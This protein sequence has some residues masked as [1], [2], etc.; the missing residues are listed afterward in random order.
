MKDKF[1]FLIVFIIL[2]NASIVSSAII[3]EEKDIINILT[4]NLTAFLQLIDTPGSY[5]GAGTQCVK[6]NAGATALEF[7]ACGSG[8]LD[9]NA[10]SICANGQVLMGDGYCLDLNDTID[11]RGT[12]DNGSWNQSFA[13]T[14]FNETSLVQSINTTNVLQLILNGTNM[15]LDILNVSTIC[16]DDDCID[17]WQAVN[18]SALGTVP[19]VCDDDEVQLGNGSCRVSDPWVRNNTFG[20]TLN[21]TKVFSLDWSNITILENQITDLTHTTDTNASTIC[22]GE[23]VLLGNSSC[24][25][26]TIF[27]AGSGDVIN[28]TAGWILNFTNI[29]SDDWSNV[30]I[31]E[32]Q[33]T[34][35]THIVDT[36]ETSRMLNLTLS[37]CAVGQQV[38]GVQTNGTV[39]CVEDSS[40]NVTY[41]LYNDTDLVNALNTTSA[42][43]TL[44]ND[45]N[46]N[47]NNI[48]SNA[49]DNVTIVEAQITDLVHTENCNSS[50]ACSSGDVAYMDI[51]NTGDFNVSANITGDIQ[52]STFGKGEETL[53]EYFDDVS[54]K[55]ILD[56]FSVTNPD[57]ALEVN[58]T[59]GEIYDVASKAIIQVNDGNASCT[60]EAVNHLVWSS[61]NTLSLQV[62]DAEGDEISVAHISCENGHVFNIH[63]E[64]SISKRESSI[65][66]GLEAVFPVIVASGLIVSEDTDVTNPLDVVLSA[67]VYYHDVQER[68]EIP[69]ILSRAKV[70]IRW[71]HNSSGDFV[72]DTNAEIDATQYDSGTGLIGTTAARFYS[73]CWFLVNDTLHWIYPTT[74]HVLVAQ[75]ISNGCPTK[76]TGF[77]NEPFL[78]RV[79]MKGDDATFPTAG[80]DRW[81]DI[82]PIIESQTGSAI[83]TDHGELIGLGDDDH[84]QYMVLTGARSLTGDWNQGNFNFT[85]LTSWFFGF[86]NWTSLQNV[87]AFVRN[88]TGEINSV[89]ASAIL[90]NSTLT[91][92]IGLVNTTLTANKFDITDQRYNETL[93]VKST[94]TTNV[95]Q[96]LLNGTNIFFAKTNASQFCIL[97]LCIDSWDAVNG[98]AIDTNETS[99]MLNLTL[100]D[101]AVGQQVIGVQTN[102]TVLCVEDSSFNVTYDNYAD[103]VSRNWTDDVVQ[104]YGDSYL[105]TFNLTYDA[106]PDSNCNATGTCVGGDVAYLNFENDG[107][108]NITGNMSIGPRPIKANLT[109]LIFEGTTSILEVC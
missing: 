95:L 106:K 22:T 5:S 6:V 90:I 43:Q 76:P 55:G 23:E 45:T 63:I 34:D 105:S 80:G 101:C 79:V 65:E 7:G 87:P 103:N 53:L 28:N 10:S 47:F 24:Q 16:I 54:N 2:V 72:N 27:A 17:S 48:T 9:G 102:G 99:R 52:S 8:T 100:S 41:A 14:L 33:V 57:G 31:T 49:W 88:Y 15:F 18:T 29:Y 38:I 70:M 46:I 44:I 11:N 86:V 58:W 104:S 39:L 75:A 37:D 30:T 13:N 93:L 62:P 66:N 51:L 3:I 40:F 77:D 19:D 73:S 32:S 56:G 67:G 69:Q 36:N 60:S 68:H 81:I 64:P 50:G 26:S 1:I 42:I 61:G 84:L 59:A 83:I 109:C 4:G 89:N 91:T 96:L 92:E 82:R 94:N 12:G 20:W 74:E 78:T 85:S 25:N 98:S 108:F 71:F 35:L 107:P 21:F 97:D